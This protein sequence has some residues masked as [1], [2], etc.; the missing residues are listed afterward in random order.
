ML[1]IICLM[2]FYITKYMKDNDIYNLSITLCPEQKEEFLKIFSYQYI[3]QKSKLH[4]LIKVLYLLKLC[5]LIS[6]KFQKIIT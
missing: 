6:N 1:N 3:L 5:L 4:E 2:Q